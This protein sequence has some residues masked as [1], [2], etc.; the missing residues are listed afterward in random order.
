MALRT[1]PGDEAHEVLPKLFIGS[2]AAAEDKEALLSNEISHILTATGAEPKYK[3]EFTYKV[4]TLGD[5]GGPLTGE[6]ASCLEFI[7]EGRSGRYSSYH[8]NI[9][10]TTQ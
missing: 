1:F 4:I 9:F 5:S 2:K 10:L 3:D 7:E 6:L 8:C